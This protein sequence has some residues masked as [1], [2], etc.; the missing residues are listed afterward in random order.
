[1]NPLQKSYRAFIES[2]CQMYGRPEMRAPLVEGFSA[3]CEGMTPG[4]IELV[5]YFRNLNIEGDKNDEPKGF[6]DEETFWEDCTQFS[7]S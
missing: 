1:M 3:L 7:G 2:V 5:K 6:R 4:N